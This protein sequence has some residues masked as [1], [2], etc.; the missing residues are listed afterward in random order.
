MVHFNRQLGIFNVTAKVS[1]AVTVKAD[2]MSILPIVSELMTL[3]TSAPCSP[4]YVSIPNG[5]TQPIKTD[6]S[7]GPIKYFRAETI[8]TTTTAKLDCAGLL[9]TR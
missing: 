8:V 9:T 7:D 5:A 6:S 4:P 1:N 2:G 3:V